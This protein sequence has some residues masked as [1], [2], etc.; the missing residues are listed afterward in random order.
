MDNNRLILDLFDSQGGQPA[1]LFGDQIAEPVDLWGG[2]GLPQ[3]PQQ[4]QMLQQMPMTSQQQPVGNLSQR[5]Q[6]LLGT[7]E[8]DGGG[9][10]QDI[11]SG[12]FSDSG[13][14]TSYGDYSQGVVQSAL[15]KPTLGG[16]I[17]IERGNDTLRQ[18]Q[19]IAQIDALTAKA[20]LNRKGGTGANGATMQIIQGLMQA[21]PGMTFE[22]ALYR[23]QTGNRQGTN[24][25][26]DGIQVMANAPQAAGQ[27]AYGK[28]A[29][30]RGAELQYAAPIEAAKVT[31][32]GE[33]TP[34][35]QK[36]LGKTQVST[37]IN[38]M[39]QQYD[40]LNK[41]GGIVN[42]KNDALANIGAASR[43]SAGGQL[44]GRTI[45]TEEQGIRN[46]LIS[47]EPLVINAIR[48]ATGMS[49]KAMDSNTELKF[50]RAAV[51][52]GDYD[53]AVQ[54]LKRIDTMYG[55]GVTAAGTGG[56]SGGGVTNWVI[57]DGKLVAQ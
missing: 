57:Y 45:G 56:T 14:G 24:L 1:D 10:I 36:N 23:Y 4:S 7:R 54:A 37:V 21:N 41:A 34:I 43:S 42:T 27:M 6:E 51:Q 20:D 48:Q 38:D 9:T 30:Q 39:I 55:G 2:E 35:E 25:T 15:G 32:K 11:L 18:L 31:G 44:I 28:E 52:A 47:M 33:I 46:K 5:I 3:M 12:R 26:P 16:Q 19:S 22:Q 8:P 40:A 53:S 49:A 17:G 29:G 13:A 50:Y